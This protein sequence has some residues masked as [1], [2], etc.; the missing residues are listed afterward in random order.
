MK[1]EFPEPIEAPCGNAGKIQ[2]RGAVPANSVRAL[3]E[4]AVI[5]KIRAGLAVARWKTGAEQTRRE[6]GVLGY[7]DFLAVEGGAF[8]VGGGK[9]FVVERIE[10]RRSE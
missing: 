6:R 4:L 3:S 10:D 2:R 8:A 7:V 9:E 5:L 1:A